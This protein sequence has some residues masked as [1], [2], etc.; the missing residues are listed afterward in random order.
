MAAAG[1][2][3]VDNG[4]DSSSSS[5]DHHHDIDRFADVGNKLADAAGD[6]IRQYFRKSFDILDKE[7]LSEL[8]IIIYLFISI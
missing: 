1:S 4:I 3:H 2:N 6:V 8:I 7:D 5:F